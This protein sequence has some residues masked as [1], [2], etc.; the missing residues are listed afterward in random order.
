[1]ERTIRIIII[2]VNAFS[3]NYFKTHRK[4]RAMAGFGVTEIFL[5]WVDYR[6]IDLGIF[7]ST[8]VPTTTQVSSMG[9]VGND[10]FRGLR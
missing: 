4:A 2:P 10:G 1:M 7:P 5:V 8:T 3:Y 6:K 9:I